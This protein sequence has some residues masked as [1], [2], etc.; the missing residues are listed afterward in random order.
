MH[1]PYYDSLFM[2]E[3]VRAGE[4]RSV[5]G[6]RWDEIGRLQLDTLIAYGLVPEH[7]LLDVGCGSL[8]GGIHFVQYLLPEHYY[9]LDMNETLLDA[10]YDVELASLGLQAR[11]PRYHLVSTASFDMSSFTIPFDRAI[12]LSLFTHL[13]LDVIRVCLERLA[14]KMA[15]GGVF[16]ASFFE[17]PAG[18]LSSEEVWHERAGGFTFAGSDP[19]HHRFRDFEY[20][21]EGL[22]WDV[23][24]VGDFDHPRGQRLINFRS[25]N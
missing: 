15:P 18:Q 25:R 17:S 6:G 21:A 10:G 7:Y 14:P 8:R 12:A 13:P 4:H 2:E 23:E 9:G 16:H 11:L 5:I 22:P 20:L 3:Q 19:Y 24:Y 1:S